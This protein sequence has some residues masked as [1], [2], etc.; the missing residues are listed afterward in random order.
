MVR[1]SL[2][3]HLGVLALAALAVRPR[4]L[5][6]LWLLT[7]LAGTVLVQRMPGLDASE[8]L[9]AMTSL[10]AVVLLAAGAVHGRRE[11]RRRLAEQERISD[12]ERARRTLLEERAR[13]ARELHDVVAHHLSVIAIQAEAAPYRVPDAPEALTGSFATIRANAVEGLGELRRVLG[14]LRDDYDPENGPQP[15]LDRL[16]D[17]VANGRDAGLTVTA[18]VDGDR[19]PLPAGVE[20]S[21]YRIVQEALSNAMRHAPGAEVT[22]E[23]AYRPAE[24]ELR[25]VNGPGRGPSAAPAGPGHGV[26]G[27]R[28]RAA[29][30]ASAA[31]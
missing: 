1:A 21:A 23:V 20:L 30:S 27:M 31:G 7:L 10:S 26:T 19:R 28:E 15:T 8:D 13:I 4:I 2:L 12:A 6:E 5:A 11:A 3:T 9:A 17:L 16:A 24:L 29:A 25:V 14:L 18:S 22:V